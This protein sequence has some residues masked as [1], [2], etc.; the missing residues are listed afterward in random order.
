MSS[1]N[2]IEL[3]SYSVNR[4]RLSLYPRDGLDDPNLGIDSSEVED[5]VDVKRVKS[6]KLCGTFLRIFGIR[7]QTFLIDFSGDRQQCAV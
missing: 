3:S 2:L 4:L 1:S 6:K 5:R 7:A